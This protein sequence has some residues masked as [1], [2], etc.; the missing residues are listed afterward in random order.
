MIYAKLYFILRLCYITSFKFLFFFLYFFIFEFSM[1][2]QSIIPYNNN[3]N[4][5]KLRLLPLIK[6][7]FNFYSVTASVQQSIENA[8][9][10]DG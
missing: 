6:T 3:K 9:L 8:I 5:A 4:V 10:S 7:I 2:Y 1:H